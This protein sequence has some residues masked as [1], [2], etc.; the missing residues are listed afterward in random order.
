M[1]NKLNKIQKQY[2][3]V[4]FALIATSL[5]AGILISTLGWKHILVLMWGLLVIFIFITRV[6]LAVKIREIESDLN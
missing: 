2:K 6:G 3:A 5:G 4:T 1:S